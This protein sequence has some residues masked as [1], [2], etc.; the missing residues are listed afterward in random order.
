ML[1]SRCPLLPPKMPSAQK[2]Q[3]LCNQVSNCII[4]LPQN[5]RGLPLPWA[6]PLRGSPQPPC[7]S[8]PHCLLRRCAAPG[9]LDERL[10]LPGKDPAGCE[11]SWLAPSPS[12]SPWLC[13]PLPPCTEGGCL[14]L[15]LA[16]SVSFTTAHHHPLVTCALVYLSAVCPLNQSTNCRWGSALLGPGI[17]PTLGWAH[18]DEQRD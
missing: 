10:R 12:S 18:G 8:P 15:L 9:P 7:L 14:G 13:G 4:L 1:A 6:R 5:P 2:S 11:S 16:I 3:I 17:S